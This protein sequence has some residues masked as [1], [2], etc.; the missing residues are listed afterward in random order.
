VTGKTG[1][2]VKV[3]WQKLS[4]SHSLSPEALQSLQAIYVGEDI[5]S[6][7][8]F[9]Y[10][11]VDESHALLP[12]PVAIV[13]PH[14]HQQVLETVQWANTYSIALVPSGGRTGLSGGACA[15]N[16]ELVV[17][18]AK[19]NRIIEFDPVGG[20]ITAESGVILELLQQYAAEHG[21]FYPVDYASRGSAQIGGAVATNAGGIRVLRYGMT[22]DWIAGLKAVT[23][24]GETLHINR[25]LSKDNAGYDLKN[26]LVGSE[27]TLAIITEVTVKLTR[28]MAEQQTLL[29]GLGSIKELIAVFSKLRN[30]LD[31]NAAEFFCANGLRVVTEQ[32]GMAKPFHAMHAFYLLLDFDKSTESL[33][34]LAE[35]LGAYDV[36]VS[37]NEKQTKNLWRYRELIASTLNPLHPYKNDIAC[38]LSNLPCWFADLEKAFMTLHG[39]LQLVWFGHLGDGNVH[40]NLVRPSEMV[41]ENF[42][43]M[44]P[45]FAKVI[46]EIT[47]KYQATAS[48]EHGIGLLKKG[49]MPCSRSTTE[50]AL[51][52]AIKKV[53]DPNGILNPEKLL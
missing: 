29:I 51:Y 47:E 19:M 27:G 40:I 43:Q 50:I 5:L 14:N 11:A 53:F 44:L 9:F 38:R 23:G 17:S 45:V 7:K 22:R 35:L 41:L 18:L 33:E 3:I 16:G 42:R 32:H 49:L 46:A 52:H 12:A 4:S 30:V 25:C 34:T 31:L 26:L 8:S 21:W 36:L 24:R 6:G 20:L 2:K 39:S 48:A 1:L 15:G 28:P 13:T 37:N 10:M